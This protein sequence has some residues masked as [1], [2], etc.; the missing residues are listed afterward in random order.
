MKTWL[1]RG[2]SRGDS[3]PRI[4]QKPQCG[5]RSVASSG[6]KVTPSLGLM[7]CESFRPVFLSEASFCLVHFTPAASE[8]PVWEERKHVSLTL[9]GGVGVAV[10]TL[11][12]TCVTDV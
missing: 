7:S 3:S 6:F 12:C 10:E 4:S 8:F 1:G 5:P 2:A 9:K 11:A